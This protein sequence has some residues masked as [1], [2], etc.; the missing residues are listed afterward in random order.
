MKYKR[1]RK[2]PVHNVHTMR[3]ALALAPFLDALGPR[4]PV[5]N[6]YVSAVTRAVGSNWQ[7][8]LNN[9]LGDCVCADT[10][11]QVML[12]TANAGAIVTPTDAEVLA[13]YEAVGGYVPGNESTDNGCD[14]TAMCQYMINTGMGG[15]KSAGTGMIDPTNLDHIGWAVQLFGA[16]RLGIVVDQ[17]MES[18]FDSKQPW[19]T[20]ADPNDPNAG[21]HDVPI[22]Q[23]DATYAYV[24]TWGALQP[25]DWS[26]VAQSAFLDEA[27]AEVYP[28]WVKVGGTA[29]SGFDL[30]GLLAK[31]AL[32]QQQ[33]SA[34]KAIWSLN[35]G[36][37]QSVAGGPPAVSVGV[38]VEF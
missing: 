16:C 21:G 1:G 36:I 14:E 19:T 35:A 31:L 8:F 3:S 7:M 29:P 22:V 17:Q 32:V 23:Y 18:Q 12:H 24:V 13:L 5:S 33:E 11:H 15:Q 26:L 38:S 2:R 27:H 9:A 30:D 25:V 20:P 6:D 34:R 10:A 37:S 28:D 4:P